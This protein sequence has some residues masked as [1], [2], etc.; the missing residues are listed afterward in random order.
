MVVWNPID[1]EGDNPFHPYYNVS[2][3]AAKWAVK[4]NYLN[5]GEG[6]KGDLKIGDFVL[7]KCGQEYYIQYIT[8]IKGKKESRYIIDMIYS[9]LK[10]AIKNHAYWTDGNLYGWAVIC[11]HFKVNF[12]DI[13]IIEFINWV[14]MNPFEVKT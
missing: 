13:N 3:F 12:E 10:S 8:H 14:D 11:E 1:N 2:Q 9:T 4:D 5:T 6:P 7:T